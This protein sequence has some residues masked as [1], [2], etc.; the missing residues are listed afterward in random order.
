MHG[1]CTH[2][3]VYRDA[4]KMLELSLEIRRRSLVLATLDGTGILIMPLGLR[5]TNLGFSQVG[6]QRIRPKSYI[7]SMSC[8]ASLDTPCISHRQRKQGCNVAPLR[9]PKNH[10]LPRNQDLCLRFQSSGAGFKVE[11]F[12]HV[13]WCKFYSIL[14]RLGIRGWR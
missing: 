14:G 7:E 13:K 8:T 12:G 5:R 11:G 2:H 9:S 1:T 4:N 10:R 6:Y 3:K